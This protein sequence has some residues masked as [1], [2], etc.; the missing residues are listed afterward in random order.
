MAH[1]V[2]TY[3]ILPENAYNWDEKGWV[4]GQAAATQRIM[5]KEAL[6]SGRITQA[7]Q[8]GSREFISLLAYCSAVGW[9]GSPT[10]IYKGTNNDLNDTW[11]EE[12]EDDDRAYF[13]SSEN[14]WSSKAFGQ[15]WLEKVFDV[16]TRKRAGNRRRLLIVD[17][18]SSHVNLTFLNKCD[19][20]RI[21]VLVLPPHS[22]HRL[23]PLDLGL[24]GPLA[25]YYTRELNTLMFES[26]G[27]VAISKRMFWGL[28]KKAWKKAMTEENIRAAFAKGGIW[29]INPHVVLSKIVRP[30]VFEP[31]IEFIR[32][33][34]RCMSIRRVQ[35]QFQHNPTTAGLQ[36]IFKSNLKLSAQH[37]I[38]E[39]TKKGL[40]RS[41]E[42][43]KKKRRRG[44]K[45]NLL[46]EKT[47]GAE[48]FSPSA[49]R[50]ARDYQKSK[51]D[52]VEQEKI[53]KAAKKEEQA[54]A[55][56]AKAQ[57]DELQKKTEG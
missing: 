31:P 53:D 38:D 47:G 40:I 42:L 5:T 55:R 37:E 52:A 46:G 3:H 49:M 19:D 54:A 51:E 27:M 6:Q 16:E 17:G 41:L 56:V 14:G 45:L 23:Q 26:I 7:A 36:L 1:A 20:L 32:T 43:E 15:K 8:D 44:K 21:I 28:F 30:K 13:G 22:T 11:L 48:L 39:H 24:F 35:R 25:Q 50:R 10:L 34:M 9:L 4:I 2:T 12:F 33:P 18:H 29:P 57:N